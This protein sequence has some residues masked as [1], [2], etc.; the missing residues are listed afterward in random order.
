[1]DLR[2]FGGRGLDD[3]KATRFTLDAVAAGHPVMLM[4]FTGHGTLFNTAALRRLQ[5][6]DDEPDPPGGFFV[7]V[8]GTRW[9]PASRMSMPS[10]S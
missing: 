1:M 9:S 10:T 4:A 6:R 8:P 3:D 2:Q 7:R 5:V